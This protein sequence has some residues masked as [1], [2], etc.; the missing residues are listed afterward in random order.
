MRMSSSPPAGKRPPSLD[1]GRALRRW[2]SS[3]A[4]RAYVVS[5]PCSSHPRTPDSRTCRYRGDGGCLEYVGASSSAKPRRRFCLG[6]ASRVAASPDD[7]CHR[8]PQ[9]YLHPLLV[10]RW[11]SVS[12]Q[13][14]SCHQIRTRTASTWITAQ[15]AYHLLAHPGPKMWLNPTDQSLEPPSCVTA[16]SERQIDA[17]SR[18]GSCPQSRSQSQRSC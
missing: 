5:V 2:W 12:A 10:S 3:S 17:I 1:P 9:A 8:A 7:D 16:C 6:S 11:D 18:P 15:Q 14:L 4:E 13:I